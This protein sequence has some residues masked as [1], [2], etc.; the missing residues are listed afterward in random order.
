MHQS[1]LNVFHKIMHELFK[2]RKLAYVIET[3]RKDSNIKM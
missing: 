3:K 1:G 2:D